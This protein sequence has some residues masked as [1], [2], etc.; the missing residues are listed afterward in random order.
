VASIKGITVREL[1]WK[2]LI[3]NLKPRLDPLAAIIPADQ[4][5]LF[6]PSFA[7]ATRLADE[8]TSQGIPI[9][10]LM[11][12]RSEDAQTLERYQRQLGIT[13][14]GAARLIG[15]QMIDSLALTGS[16][17]YFRTGTDIAV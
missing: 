5:V 2:P 15:P 7:A 6:L 1:D 13:L 11:E 3:R 16:D 4:H 10:R 9:L 14:S 12:P 8:A 17:P